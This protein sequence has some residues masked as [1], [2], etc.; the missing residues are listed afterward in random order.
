MVFPPSA[1]ELFAVG[2]YVEAAR[3]GEA[4]AWQTWAAMGLVGRTAE[5]LAGLE[6]FSDPAAR[7]HTGVALWIDGRDG[8]AEAALQGVD[9]P[10][11]RALL[12]LVRRER[13]E[14]LAQL[15]PTRKGPRNLLTGMRSDEK[16]HVLNLSFHPE[17]LPNRPYLDIEAL[18]KEIPRPDLF[19]CH[20]LEW[21]LIPPRLDLLPC[22]VFGEASDFDLHIQALHPWMSLFDEFVVGGSSEWA[23]LRRLARV[24]V[25]VYSKCF[26]VPA[27][28][29]SPRQEVLRVDVS[30]TGTL[31][32]PYHPDKAHLMC[33]VLAM[34][35]AGSIR[36]I[37]GFLAGPD[38]NRLQAT[39]ASTFAYCRWT[40][41]THTKALEALAMGLPV[42]QPEGSALFVHVGEEEGTL[43]YSPQAGGLARALRRILADPEEFRRRAARGAEIVR[44]EY[45]LARVGS[46]HLR[47]LTYLATRPG[48]SRRSPV[49]PPPV[50]KRM[51]LYRGSVQ[52]RM[53]ERAVLAANLERLPAE[54]DLHQRLDRARE[55]VLECA[56]RWTEPPPGAQRLVAR[57]VRLRQAGVSALPY[58]LVRAVTGSIRRGFVPS[59]QELAETL[60]EDVSSSEA[61]VDEA[62]EIYRAVAVTW[63]ASL[64]ARFDMIRT[65]LWLGHDGHRREA[66]RELDAVLSAD[67]R[68]WRCDPLE[69]VFP[70]DLLAAH[71]NYRAYFEVV[72]E[73][74]AGGASSEEERVH[75]ILAALH[76]M[77]QRDLED[78]RAACRLDPA[79]P[80]Y[81]LSLARALADA[82]EADEAASLLRPLALDSMLLLEAGALLRRLGRMDTEVEALHRR[83]RRHLI[84]LERYPPGPLPRLRPGARPSYG[85]SRWFW[86]VGSLLVRRL[87]QALLARTLPPSAYLKSLAILQESP[88]R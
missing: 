60:R 4:T 27:D 50:Q 7:L 21:H 64:V 23:L 17:D 59:R 47:F 42:A 67:P 29:P 19:V 24:P 22:P 86:E 76:H 30:A 6:G 84:L 74:L 75:L 81:R 25:H 28:F 73:E 54:G 63:P 57:A 87:V 70:H 35:E 3:S 66:A 62:M 9:H 52:G 51:I 39:A 16:F 41:A 80:Y 15:D 85:A 34:E 77:R 48:F 43:A 83:A 31:L 79:F 65:A 68:G 32:H 61:L 71:F 46:Q 5:A 33:E 37:N 12:D 53:A 78:L 82:G 18:L 45:D 40:G 2:N 10:H 58:S 1:A 56:N 55:L 36:L 44:R 38:Y 8:D 20:M 88:E 14:V 49:V 11:A 69:D 13:I 26:G 72:Q